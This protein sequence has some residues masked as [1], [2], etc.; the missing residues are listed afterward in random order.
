MAQ[1]FHPSANT[2]AKASIVGGALLVA[3][4]GGI[5]WTVENSGYVTSQSVIRE[6]PVPFSH[7]HHVKGLGI[8]CR[9][10]HTSVEDS[11]FAGIPATKTC[12]TCHSQVWTN[13]EVLRPVRQSWATNTPIEWNRVHDLADF[14]YFNHSIHVAKGV[15]CSTCHGQVDRMPLMWQHSP[16][17]MSWC[18]ECHRA[19][20]KFVRPREQIYNMDYRVER[21]SGRPEKTQAELG[22]KLVEEYRIRKDQLTNCSTCH[23]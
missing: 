13:T 19:P 16:L 17:T 14:A 2:L 3:L 20:E 10:C 15:G 8:D 21:D 12:M 22:A 6:Q 5:G 9:Y 18:L 23:R 1:L 7:E 11:H 4:L